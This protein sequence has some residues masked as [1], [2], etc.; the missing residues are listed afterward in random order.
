MFFDLGLKA[1]VVDLPLSV[2]VPKS[3]AAILL[4]FAEH[5]LHFILHPAVFVHRVL[6]GD[7][8]IAY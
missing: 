2:D 8:P 1:G 3:I 4:L 5:L 6:N 7:Q